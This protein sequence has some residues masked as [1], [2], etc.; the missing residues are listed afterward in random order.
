VERGL[1]GR[2]GWPAK[3]K[4]GGSAKWGEKG[5]RPKKGQM[6]ER[7]TTRVSLREKRNDAIDD[8]GLASNGPHP[9][10]EDQPLAKNFFG[11]LSFTT[12][13]DTPFIGDTF[14]YT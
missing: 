9:R 14:R 3:E 2:R 1:H 6:G 10:T 12:K 7:A 4:G 8:S 11:I 13:R 5:G